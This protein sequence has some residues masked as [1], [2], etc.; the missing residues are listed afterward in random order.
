MGP[1]SLINCPL[2][3]RSSS[4]RNNWLFMIISTRFLRSIS[5]M[6]ASISDGF[7][8][9]C[10]SLLSSSLFSWPLLIAVAAAMLV[11]VYMCLC[12]YGFDSRSSEQVEGDLPASSACA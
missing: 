11:G 9:C 12:L 10:C 7:G 1:F 5:L 3:I 2:I 6:S 4:S 8:G